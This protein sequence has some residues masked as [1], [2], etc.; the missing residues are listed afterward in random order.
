M[1]LEFVKKK[2]LC[3][4]SD[5]EKDCDRMLA[6]SDRYHPSAC[7]QHMSSKVYKQ[8]KS[9]NNQKTVKTV[10]RGLIRLVTSLKRFNSYEISQEKDYL[11]IQVTA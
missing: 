3:C 5:K 7:C 1:W 4:N 11:L 10:R 6:L 8:T 9:V 2:V